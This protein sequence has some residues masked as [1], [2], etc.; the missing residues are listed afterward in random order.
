MKG[1]NWRITMTLNQCIF[2]VSKDANGL[3][4]F[5]QTTYNGRNTNF[6]MVADSTQE[7]TSSDNATAGQTANEVTQ[8]GAY[9]L[10]VST[11]LTVS[12]SVG[13]CNYAQHSALNVTAHESNVQLHVPTIVL[14]P[15]EDS[16][17][18]AKPQRTVIYD[19]VLTFIQTNKIGL[20]ND[21]VTN[22]ISHVKRMIICPVLSSDG[23][24]NIN[25]HVSPFTCEPSVCSPYKIQNFQVR[26]AN[27]NIYPNAINYSYESFLTELNGKYAIGHNLAKG[28][29]GSRISLKDYITTYGYIVV[30]LKRKPT[31]DEATPLSIQISGR[32]VSPKRLDFY[33]FVEQEKSFTYDSATG[34]RL[35]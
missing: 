25:P 34:A 16:R 33:I 24:Q 5:D 18:L 6:L 28:I 14:S 19:E 35:D 31:P 32:I 3:M 23:N 7:M 20:F 30:D 15:A 22:G 26:M 12:C 17:L 29:A 1:A 2:N 9:P 8:G 21:L 27:H 10:A 11:V 13:K 4:T